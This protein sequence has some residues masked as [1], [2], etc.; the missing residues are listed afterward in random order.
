M[1]RSVAAQQRQA[2]WRAVLSRQAHSGHSAAAFCKSEGIAA[3]TF[4]WWRAKLRD[5]HEEQATFSPEERPAAPFIE[6]SDLAAP[7]SALREAQTGFVLRLD[8][9]GG[10]VLTIARR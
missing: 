10:I 3:Q 6:L 4:Y 5:G 2:H 8:L 7:G 9:P 1:T